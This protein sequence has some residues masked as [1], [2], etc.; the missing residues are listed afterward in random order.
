[1][2]YSGRWRLLIILDDCR[3]DVFER[4]ALPMLRHIGIKEYRVVESAGTCTV[5]W[6][7]ETFTEPI[8]AVYISNN[9][10]L[11]SSLPREEKSKLRHFHK[12]VEAWRRTWGRLGYAETYRAELAVAL[13]R[14]LLSLGKKV[15]LHILQPHPPY[16][17][18][19]H[20]AKYYRD[21]AR[22]LKDAERG[23]LS[24]DELLEGYVR[25]LRYALS[26]IIDLL[27]KAKGEAVITSDHGECFGERGVWGHP[28]GRHDIPELKMVP[29]CS[30]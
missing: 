10:M 26:C 19:E 17:F 16:V 28:C 24:R 15:I 13:A 21:L 6:F 8:D 3:A 5:E 29:W 25:N 20:L 1:L 12:F 2:I 18:V 4:V 9:P 22:M 30:V 23:R 14:P 11:P 27:G 7:I